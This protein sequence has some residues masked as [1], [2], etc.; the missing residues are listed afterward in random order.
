MSQR[1]Q[2]ARK[3]QQERRRQERR[4]ARVQQRR[5]RAA[6]TPATAS[7]TTARTARG[8]APAKPVRTVRN[9][10]PLWIAAGVAAGALALAAVA[11]LIY[12]LREPLPGEKFPSNGNDHVEFGQPHGAYFS[13]PPTSGWHTAEIPRPG[14]YTLGRTPEEL[15]HF[16]EHGGVWVLYTC[17][18]GC[19]ELADQLKDEV[20]RAID[21]NL[22]VAVAPYPAQGY[23]APEK[24]INV[25]AWQYK[26]S[27]DEFDRG[28]IQEFIERHACRYNPEGGPYCP[29]VKGSAN[30]EAK[31]A[32]EE[33]FNAVTVVTLT[34][35][36]V[37]SGS[38]AAAT[39]PVPTP[40]PTA[41]AAVSGPTPPPVA[42]ATAT[43]AR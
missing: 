4:N 25:T 42:T 17:P 35:T 36:A 23:Q 6:A 38:P 40:A 15:G 19:P 33:G 3:A 2:D 18:D 26:L 8:E 34:P 1:R 37:P 5:A 31:D 41:T 11:F 29:I 22:P 32:G 10:R 20:N 39:T 21:K 27:M 43:P 14:V 9:T 13:N 28:K 16:M 24:P 7:T 30:S 12:T